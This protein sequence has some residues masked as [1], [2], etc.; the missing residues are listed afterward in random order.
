FDDK[1]RPIGARELAIS[2]NVAHH[3]EV[4]PCVSSRD[5]LVIG[6]DFIIGHSVLGVRK[7]SQGNWLPLGDQRLDAATCL[8]ARRFEVVFSE[9]PQ[10]WGFDGAKRRHWVVTKWR[11][12]ERILKVLARF[13]RRV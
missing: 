5:A 2:R 6:S 3:G 13:G 1:A 12:G 11:A 9:N 8:S 10:L 4:A 7:Y